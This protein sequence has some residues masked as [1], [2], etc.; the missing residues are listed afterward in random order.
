MAQSTL[1]WLLGV[2]APTVSKMLKSLEQRGLVER[3]R[4]ARD[5][6]CLIV[7]LTQL[8][9]VALGA[10]FGY[11]VSDTPWAEHLAARGVLGDTREPDEPDEQ[12]EATLAAGRQKLAVLAPLLANM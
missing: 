2:S 5:G 6:R 8:G 10:A 3:D 7:R 4:D 12:V 11:F 1:R 9:R